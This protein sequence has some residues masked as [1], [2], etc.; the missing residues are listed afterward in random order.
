MKLI[1][2]EQN[3][4]PGI[5]NLVLSLFAD[6]ICVAFDS[7]VEC[8]WA[9]QRDKCVVCGNPVRLS[10]VNGTSKAAA[11]RHFFPAVEVEKV[12]VILGGS[13]G[14][15][16]INIAL[17]NVYLQM[18][19]ENDGLSIIWQTG[20]DAF[21]EMESLVTT[22]PSLLLSPSVWKVNDVV[23]ACEIVNCSGVEVQ[24]QVKALTFP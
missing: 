7:S 1:I 9:W 10:L 18:L 16:A 3:S 13:L 11:R 8:F 14:A 5:A 22:Y 23:A 20:T 6:K 17:F 12:V 2:Q 15:N 24:C 4:V 21:P 19:S